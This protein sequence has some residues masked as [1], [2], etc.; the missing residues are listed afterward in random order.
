TVFRRDDIVAAMNSTPRLTSSEPPATTVDPG[1]ELLGTDEMYRADAL[2][3]ESGISGVEL[4]ANAG[5]AVAEAIRARWRPRPTA[6][7]CGP[8]NNGGDGFV[9]ARLL[10]EAGWPVRLALS[11]PVERLKG[12]AAV[13]EARWSGPVTA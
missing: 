4:M 7:L 13:H 10:E 2:A 3:M 1:P 11:C 6:V 9:V 8:G 5:A 12:D